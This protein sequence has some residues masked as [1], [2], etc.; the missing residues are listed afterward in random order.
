MGNFIEPNQKDK[1][2]NE[3]YQ[4]DGDPIAVGA[5]AEVF[6]VIETSSNKVFA[7]KR[8]KFEDKL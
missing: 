4:E 6:K 8:V 7:K 2:L 5:S 3:K 1:D